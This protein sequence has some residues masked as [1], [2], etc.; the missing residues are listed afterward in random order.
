MHTDNASDHTAFESFVM[1]TDLYG[2]LTHAKGEYRAYFRPENKVE[3][4]RIASGRWKDLKAEENTEFPSLKAGFGYMRAP[5]SMNPSPYVSR[6]AFDW[7]VEFG[8]LPSC[9]YH[10]SMLEY[11]DL[12]EYFYDISFGSHGTAHTTIGGIFGCDAMEDMVTQ[13]FIANKEALYNACSYM[14]NAIKE[15]YRQGYL[16]VQ[17][18]CTVDADDYTSSTCTFKCL[19]D[20]KATTAASVVYTILESNFA[21]TANTTEVGL[22]LTQLIF[23][24]IML[25]SV[26]FVLSCFSSRSRNT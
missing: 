24:V 1:T 21:S 6:Y 13:G 4:A 23:V 5:W 3:D 14:G 15:S 25:D 10:Y 16:D 11:T 2:T 26:Y 22:F 7:E 18:D 17:K 8:V 19:T 20:A 12:M 9:Y